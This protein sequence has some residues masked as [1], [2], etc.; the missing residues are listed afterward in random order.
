MTYDKTNWVDG[1]TPVSAQNMNN[2]ETQYEKAKAD[3]DTHK[4]DDAA[5]GISSKVTGPASVVDGDIAMFN[6]A[7]GKLI[8]SSGIAVL[9]T[10][11]DVLIHEN[12]GWGEV[13][14]PGWVLIKSSVLGFGGILKISFQLHDYSHSGATAT[15]QGQIYRNGEPVGTL[16]TTTSTTAVTFTEEIAGWEPGDSLELW[17]NQIEPPVGT[18]RR[19]RGGNVRIFINKVAILPNAGTIVV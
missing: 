6:G 18:N 12:P 19:I 11:G 13:G 7:T 17:I 15:A 3:L 2:L 14:Q 9:H 10:A 16:R 1:V 8:K 4:A 5:H